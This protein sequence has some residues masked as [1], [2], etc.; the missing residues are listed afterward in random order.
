M[1][2]AVVDEQ[3]GL[4]LVS[5][6][7]GGPHGQVSDSTV[8]VGYET[9]DGTATGGDY[10]ARAGTLSFAPGQ[11]AKTVAIPITDDADA[12]GAERFTLTLA[13]P[14]NAT[15][16]A[17]TG[18]VTIGASDGPAAAAPALSAPAGVVV[19]E[20]DGYV[21]LVVR[22]SA[23]GAQPVTVGYTTANVTAGSGTACFGDYIGVTGTLTFAPGETTKVVRVEIKNCGDNEGAESFGFNLSGA[24]NATLARAGGRVL[25]LNGTTSLVSLSIAPLGP[26]IAAGEDRQFLATAA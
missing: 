22:L 3:D 6:L 17:G 26:A 2:D 4:A 10:Q 12:E 1:R 23:P 14:G 24:V 18:T 5:V 20:P 8:T 11:T 19:G 25:I 9:H 21:D 13:N 15:I 16:A 7:L